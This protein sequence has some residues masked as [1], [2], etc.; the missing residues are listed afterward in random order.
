[1]IGKNNNNIN[2]WSV[3][4]NSN[5]SNN[6]IKKTCD[7]NKNNCNKNA[8]ICCNQNNQGPQIPISSLLALFSPLSPLSPF[9]PSGCSCPPGSAATVT[10]GTT[11]SGTPAAVTNS[12]TSTNAVLNFTI[13]PATVTVGTTMTGGVGTP[14]LVTNSGPDASNAVF[15]FTIPQGPI[16]PPGSSGGLIP[17]STGIILSGAT[18]TSAAPILMGFGSHAV[19]V[20]SGGESTSPPEAGGFAFPIPFSG[21]LRN[22]E[23]S[24]DL[25][26]AS[27]ATIP[28]V[29]L[30][31]DFTV[32]L[33]PSSTNLGVAHVASN[34]VTTGLTG[35]LTFPI[36]PYVAGTFYSATNILGGTLNVF[37]GDRVG[38]R[39]R[40]R[41]ATDGSAADVTQLSFSASLSFT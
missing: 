30:I 13:P 8:I 6:N 17:F 38:I 31:Y 2:N 37:A 23:I 35:S 15:N 9:S 14:A 41:V 28:T 12:G 1:M 29:G 36:G 24:C 27:I 20:I 26:L 11:T 16:G 18:V 33:A 5:N 25:L 3:W 10:V 32:F 40:T 34:Y 22:L 39:I 4:N 21:T 7:N 19:E